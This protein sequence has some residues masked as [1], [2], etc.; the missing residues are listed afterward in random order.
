MCRV[1][2]WLFLSSLGLSY[3]IHQEVWYTE[4]LEASKKIF[5][6]GIHNLSCGQVIH[7]IHV[8]S[9]KLV[10]LGHPATSSTL[11]GVER[12]RDCSILELGHLEL[13]LI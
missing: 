10:V 9:S 8:D 3:F 6:V 7:N 1:V 12:V 2:H 4:P 11:F 13:H 5:L